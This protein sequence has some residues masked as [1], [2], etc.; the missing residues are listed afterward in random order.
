MF[1]LCEVIVEYSESRWGGSVPLPPV[2]KQTSETT[3]QR[4]LTSS[5]LRHRL[6]SLSLIPR[7]HSAFKN[8]RCRFSQHAP[9]WSSSCTHALQMNQAPIYILLLSR[10]CQSY[11]F[12]IRFVSAAGHGIVQFVVKI[13]GTWNPVGW[14]LITFGYCP[15][16]AGINSSL[17]SSS[18]SLARRSF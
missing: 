6:H 7:T 10:N 2:D 12:L 11:L 16:E 9:S 14:N 3:I 4:P 17:A 8:T 18:S 1:T 15:C 5:S 13:L